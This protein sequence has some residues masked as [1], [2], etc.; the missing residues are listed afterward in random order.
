[1]ITVTLYFKSICMACQN[2]LQ[3]GQTL[4][5]RLPHRLTEKQRSIF[6]PN[7]FLSPSVQEYNPYINGL[8]SEEYYMNLV[9]DAMEPYL[10][11][12]GISFTR[13]DPDDTLQQ[14]IALSNAGNYDFHLALPFQRR[15]TGPRRTA[16]RVRHLLLRHQHPGSTRREDLCRKPEGHLS[17]SHQS[18]N[19]G[20]HH[21]GRA[22]SGKGSVQSHRT[23]VPMTTPRTPSGSSTTSS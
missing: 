4:F 22:A 1:M 14:A 23:G 19:G 17:G 11:S 13:N 3:S 8:G 7:L 6:M 2:N 21:A 12:C 20:K 10:I 15:T 18:P 5:Q 16:S 9:A